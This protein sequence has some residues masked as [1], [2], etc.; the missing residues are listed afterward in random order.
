MGGHGRPGAAAEGLRVGPAGGERLRVQ[1]E[2]QVEVQVR[3]RLPGV[4]RVLL[5]SRTHFALGVRRHGERPFLLGGVAPEHRVGRVLPHG[6]RG[7]VEGA[8][9]TAVRIEAA[10][11]PVDRPLAADL[12]EGRD[13]Q[14]Q[15]RFGARKPQGARFQRERRAGDREVTDR[16]A[17]SGPDRRL[18]GSG[19]DLFAEMDRFRRR[20]ARDHEGDPPR[21]LLGVHLRPRAFPERNPV[22]GRSD[23]RRIAGP[24]RRL[25]PGDDQHFRHSGIGGE[26]VVL[27]TT[28]S[29]G[30][31]EEILV[32]GVEQPARRVLA[33]CG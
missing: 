10:D 31:E 22:R 9:V 3:S 21:R 27:R 15:F 30:D 6:G 13:R 1:A 12:R 18:D 4:V 26:R 16:G 7:D 25:L 23:L 29:D 8:P 2:V 14:R 24:V 11:I 5:H 33:V 20:P 17:A 28:P 32:V 19:Q